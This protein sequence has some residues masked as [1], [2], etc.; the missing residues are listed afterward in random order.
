V[1]RVRIDRAVGHLAVTATLFCAASANAALVSYAGG[2]E[3]TTPYPQNNVIPLTPGRL[4]GNVQFNSAVRLEWTFFGYEAGYVNRLIVGPT[5]DISNRATTGTACVTE[6]AAGALQYSFLVTDFSGRQFTVNQGTNYDPRTNDTSISPTVFFG[7]IAG[8]DDF[9]IALDDGGAGPDDNH[10][11]WVGRV[12]V[13]AV[14]DPAVGGVLAFGLLLGA[15]VHRV[16]TR[17]P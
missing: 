4:G 1:G 16:R 9:W 11:D 2:A 6:Q 15:G 13:V 10:D 17:R 3:Y 7:L 12:R 5:C 14:P 8:T